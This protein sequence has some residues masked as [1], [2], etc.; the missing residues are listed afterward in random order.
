QEQIQALVNSISRGNFAENTIA[1]QKCPGFDTDELIKA[2]IT[3]VR[4]K[5]EAPLDVAGTDHE[6][7]TS[8]FETR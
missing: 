1:L 4:F 7:P 6:A 5:P 2:G 8:R 3:V